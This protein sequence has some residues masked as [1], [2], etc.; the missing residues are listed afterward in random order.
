MQDENRQLLVGALSELALE[1]PAERLERLIGY[2]DFLLETN[3]QFNLTGYRTEFESL[4][5]NLLNSLAPWK[6]VLVK[7]A[8][9]DVGTGGGLPGLPLAI[10][11][12]MPSMAL[13]ESKR[14]KC[15]FL[16]EACARYAPRVRV[17][18]SDVKEVKERFT[19]I[20]SSA[21]GTLDKL[22]AGTVRQRAGGCRM[23]A[24]KGRAEVIAQEIAACKP[25]ERDWNVIPFSVPHMPD[26]QRHLC[27]HVTA[28]RR[29][30]A[31][32]RS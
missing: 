6:H 9:A 19:Q 30:P 16:R 11:L 8:T 5:N 31:A 13:I 26:V 1:L 4:K 3:A 18:Q 29:K 2:H 22:L 21:Y 25:T 32:L 14:K 28:V 23:L 24:W 20:L 7:S 15:D 17:L 10:A 12:D 27:V